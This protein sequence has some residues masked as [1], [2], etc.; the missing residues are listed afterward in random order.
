MFPVRILLSVFRKGVQKDKDETKEEEREKRIRRQ[1]RVHYDV[2]DSDMHK[3]EEDHP[4]RNIE[5]ILMEEKKAIEKEIGE[6]I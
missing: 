6:L 4:F 3:I 2:K 1:K 5:K